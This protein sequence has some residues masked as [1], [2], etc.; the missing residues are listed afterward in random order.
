MDR[1]VLDKKIDSILRCLN[2]VEQRLPESE[3]AFFKD[4]DAQ[5]VVVLNLTRAIQTAVDIATHL[6]SSSNQPVPSTMAE[7]FSS[8]QKI[9]VIT[10]EI[11][12]KMIKSVG[13]RNVAVHNYDDVDLS[14]TYAIAS[15]HLNDFKYFI[16][17]VLSYYDSTR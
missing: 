16:R 6:L 12:E 5:D 14:I 7:S 4:F 3:A 10:T 9:N 15:Q 11:A 8:L 13:F 17:Q 1:I 2:R